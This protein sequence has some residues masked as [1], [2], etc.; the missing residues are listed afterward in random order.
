MNQN[1]CI[2]VLVFSFNIEDFLSVYGVV[3]VSMNSLTVLLHMLLKGGSL[4]VS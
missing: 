1:L 3:D 2:S 4:N